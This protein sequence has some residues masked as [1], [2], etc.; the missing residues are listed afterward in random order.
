MAAVDE[1]KAFDYYS[2][3][4]MTAAERAGPAV[5]KNVQRLRPGHQVPCTASE[6]GAGP[7]LHSR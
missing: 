6:V 5:V 3:A 7:L 1:Q 2:H 4:V